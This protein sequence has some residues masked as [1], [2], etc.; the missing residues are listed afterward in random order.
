MGSWGARFGHGELNSAGGSLQSRRGPASPHR[1]ARVASLGTG[2][3]LGEGAGEILGVEV[4]HHHARQRSSRSSL[5]PA[6]KLTLRAS[7]GARTACLRDHPQS[8]PEAVRT[9]IVADGRR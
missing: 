1:Q 6:E 9:S 3:R 5:R 8:P 7:R 4:E 2:I